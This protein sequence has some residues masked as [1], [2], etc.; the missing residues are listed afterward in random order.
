[1]TICVPTAV[2]IH[3]VWINVSVLVTVNSQKRIRGGAGHILTPP[4]QLLLT[5]AQQ[6]VVLFID[7]VSGQQE[8]SIYRDCSPYKGG[9]EPSPAVLTGQRRGLHQPCSP[10]RWTVEVVWSTS[11]ALTQ[12]LQSKRDSDYMSAFLCIITPRNTI[13]FLRVLM[14]LWIKWEPWIVFQSQRDQ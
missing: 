4:H 11:S 3:W 6:Q 10:Q 13:I 12:G 2:L 9:P 14:T 8:S 1:M 5:S 7:L